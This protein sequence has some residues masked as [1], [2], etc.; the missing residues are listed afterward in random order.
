ML[1]QQLL[2]SQAPSILAPLTVGR[3]LHQLKKVSAIPFALPPPTQT[4]RCSS[5]MPLC[6]PACTPCRFSYSTF[7][8]CERHRP[9]TR[10]KG[11]SGTPCRLPSLLPHLSSPPPSPDHLCIGEGNRPLHQLREQQ[12]LQTSAGRMHP[13][14]VGQAWPQS[15]CVKTE[16][17]ERRKCQLTSWEACMHTVP[18]DLV[19]GV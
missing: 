9:C 11:K 8:L 1:L 19:G 18:S 2:S 15:L 7:L 16:R 14:E 10:G 13:L 4:S 6:R 3:A 17:Q 5:P 12:V